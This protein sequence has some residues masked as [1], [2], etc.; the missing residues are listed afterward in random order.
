MESFSGMITVVV[1]VG[2]FVIFFLLIMAVARRYKKVGPNEV[3]VISGGRHKLRGVGAPEVTGYRIRKGGGAF[4]LPLI[5]RVDVMSLEVMTLD[6]TTPEVYTKPGVPIVVDGVAQVKIRGDEA[7]IRT[8][9]EQFLG[10]SVEQIKE[11]ALQTVEGHLRAII[12][13]LTVEEIYRNRDQF[14]SSVQD[15][16]VSDMANMGLEIVSFTLKDIRDSHGYLDALGKPK[17]A[18][19][20]R[21]AI[22][23]QAEADR[24]ANIRSANARQAGETAKFQAET[25]IAESER[26]YKSQKAQ[27][28]AAVNLKRAE[29]DLAYDI[30]K[31]R[32]SQELKREEVQIAIV[33]KEQQV[34]VQEKEIQ[35]RER[36]LE[37]TIKRQADAE[38]YRVE[39]EATAQKAKF[40]LEATGQAEATRQRGQ[41]DA[42]VIR[43]TGQ[44]EAQVVALKGSAEAE[45]MA[46]RAAS[47]KQYNEAAVLEILVKALP[48]IARAVSE[49]LSKTDR[50]TMISTGGDGVGASKLTGDVA[51]VM[52]EL[53][54]VIESLS[55]ID[56]RKLVDAVPALKEAKAED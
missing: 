17:I 8:A 51:K 39:T 6:I 56:L 42:D 36:E 47:F 32:T 54:P 1:V 41:A 11:V 2:L 9:A 55:G 14:A 30:Q 7:S 31:N 20:K 12:G 25:K 18:E 48:E 52:A 33:E 23:A 43:V 49:P 40:E 44:S 3:M 16:A 4:I 5:E 13:T 35:R 10:K 19:I 34:L 53:P 38:R 22:I 21:D 27:Y 37:A 15:V 50:I 45:A 46:K 24:D 28:D 29:A 26:D